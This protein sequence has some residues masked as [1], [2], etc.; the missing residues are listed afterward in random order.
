MS[1]W[2]NLW[3][4]EE[5]R[6]IINLLHPT[7]IRQHKKV[8]AAQ[9][10][11]WTFFMVWLNSR[12]STAQQVRFCCTIFSV[13]QLISSNALIWTRPDHFG[14]VGWNRFL[15]VLSIWFHMLWTTSILS[16]PVGLSRR[17]RGREDT[18]S[19]RIPFLQFFP[20]LPTLL[21]LTCYLDCLACASLWLP[22]LYLARTW[23]LGF[24][25]FQPVR[26]AHP[27]HPTRFHLASRKNFV[28]FKSGIRHGQTWPQNL[29]KEQCCKNKRFLCWFLQFFA[30]FWQILVDLGYFAWANFDPENH[31]Q[32]QNQHNWKT[33]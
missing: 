32:I 12:L 31:A 22:G 26:T 3:A 19:Q 21:C 20:S 1:V 24:P 7:S 27:P 5:V 10:T 4:C 29:P 30:F 8:L 15:A 23:E 16:R 13:L 6:L 28:Q 9:C 2:C 33:K 18:Q 14:G 11:L 25:R 17:K